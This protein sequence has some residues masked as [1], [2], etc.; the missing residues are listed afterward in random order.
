VGGKARRLWP[1]A[2]IAVVLAV[3]GILVWAV[4]RSPHRGDLSTFGGFVVAVIAPVASLIVY[5]TKLRRPG[6]AGP[7]RP[8]S[9]LADSLAAAVREQWRQAALERRL[10]Q[11]EP[12]PVRWVRSARPLAGPVSAAVGSRQFPPLPGLPAAAAGRLR[13]GQLQDLHA[14]YGGLGSGRLVIIGGP[15]SGKS[16]AAVRLVLAALNYRAQM[17]EE[18]RRLVP[19]PVLVTVHGWDP[20]TER[21]GHWLAGR[22]QQTYPLFAG[23]GGLEAATE[24]VRTSRIA[25]ILD[26][27]DEISEELRPAALR[28][29]S[30]QADF[31]VVVLSRSDEMAA[32]ASQELLQGAVVLELQDVGAKVA[33]DYLT[34]VQRR[35]LPAGWGELTDRLRRAPGSPI[36][37]ALSLPLTLT[38]VRDTYRGGDD[39]GELLDFCDAGDHGASRESIED[40]LLDRVLPAAYAP[41]PGE[42]PPRYELPAARLALGHVAA[43]M[44]RDGTR[45]L[46]WWRIPAWASAVPRV[47]ATGLVFGLLFWLG[48][49]PRLGLVAVPVAALGYLA[50]L[51]DKSPRR[52]AALRWRQLF[53]R[54]SLA[55]GLQFAVVGGLF[56]GFVF[57]L[58]SGLTA[59]RT[60]GLVAAVAT[61]LAG[62]LAAGLS[63]PAADDASP[64][65]PPAS[66]HRD[67][68]FGLIVGV[69]FGISVG[70]GLGFILGTRH[71]LGL[72]PGLGYGLLGGVVFGLVW[73]LSFPLTWTASL[74]FA[75]LT[76]R[77]HTPARLLRFLEDARQRDVLR[78]VG[79]IYQFRHARLQDRLAGQAGPNEPA[80]R[81]ALRM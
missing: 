68:A 43:R 60:V 73:G 21:V 16:G 6:D 78:T 22:L 31:R 77:W 10:L 27:L 50:G 12:I 9:E 25:A 4:W 2:A 23:K 28:A 61:G 70:L 17:T 34:R 59:G 40:Y 45:D 32:A 48:G 33:A 67:Q 15:G 52:M 79:P 37:R 69:V 1:L 62:T 75:Q 54:S 72:V 51:R 56:G 11:P 7:G 81:Q 76:L 49:G 41:R 30:D 74:A 36:A 29:L 65:T 57:G 63:R 18:E 24:L 55:V 35:P 20:G 46:A 53:S 13:G 3:A 19:V 42:P 14:V 38:L 5:L 8:L 80:A 44:N 39:V 26:G 66:W 58:A 71:V 64:L 47:V